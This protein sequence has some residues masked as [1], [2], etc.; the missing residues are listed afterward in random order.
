MNRDAKGGCLERLLMSDLL[1][2]CVGA[3]IVVWCPWVLLT[4]LPAEDLM[5]GKH[6]D[7]PRV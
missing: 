1:R 7:L 3:W 6:E 2:R 4:E 5:G